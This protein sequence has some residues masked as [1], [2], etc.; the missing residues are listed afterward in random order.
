M[1][2]GRVLAVAVPPQVDLALE[3]LVAKSAGERFVTGVLTHVGDQI[4]RLA[5]GFAAHDA[6]VRLLTCNS[7]TD[8]K[9]INIY[10]PFIILTC[11]ISRCYYLMKNEINLTEIGRA[12]T[13]GKNKL[14]GSISNLIRPYQS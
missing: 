6:L 13:V 8:D 1:G 5:E 2:H 7:Q 11:W 12:Q 4:G 9:Q 3:G 14:T 10:S